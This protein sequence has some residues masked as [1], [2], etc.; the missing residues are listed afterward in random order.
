MLVW[1]LN[2]SVWSILLPLLP[3]LCKP[4]LGPQLWMVQ[5]GQMI[6]RKRVTTKGRETKR[7]QC[8]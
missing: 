3:T 4:S 5:V 2:A 1:S 7:T 6:T 8:R